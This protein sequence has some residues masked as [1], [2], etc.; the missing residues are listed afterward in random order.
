MKKALIATMFLAAT[1]MFAAPRISVGIGFGAPAQ[2]AIVRP[3]CPGPGYTWVD[4]YYTNGAWVAG[5]WAAPAPVVRYDRD[6]FHRDDR[7]ARRVIVPER[8]VD[9][10]GHDRDSH[11]DRR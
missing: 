1:S 5:Y 6:D 3:A 4:G 10:D 2:V 7:D 9:R 8:H 11:G